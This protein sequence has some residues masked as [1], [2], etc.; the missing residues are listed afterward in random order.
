[1]KEPRARCK[2][3]HLLTGENL[4]V[5]AKLRRYRRNNGTVREFT[6]YERECCECHRRHD[7]DY[8]YRLVSQQRRHD[9]TYR[10]TRERLEDM[11]QVLK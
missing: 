10:I 4:R 6:Q 8:R 11:K 1:M 9:A 2:H 3:G 7:S 5:K